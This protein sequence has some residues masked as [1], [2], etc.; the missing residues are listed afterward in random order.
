MVNN[1]LARA[2]TVP[3]SR[4]VPR[5]TSLPLIVIARYA[6]QL[7]KETGLI[8]IYPVDLL[9]ITDALKIHVIKNSLVHDLLPGEHGKAY[10]NGEKWI[11]IYDDTRTLKERRFTIA[12]E[13]GHVIL[14][15]CDRFLSGDKADHE[16]EAD[17]FAACLL[18]KGGCRNGK[19]K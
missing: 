2:S 1:S 10:F 4:E 18:M 8:G 19:R 12:H 13:L 11:F 6:R 3:M 16:R 5:D 15:H 9:R 17:L 14:D 7:L